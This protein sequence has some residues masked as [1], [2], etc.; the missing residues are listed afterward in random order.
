MQSQN[1]INEMF[2]ESQL[3]ACACAPSIML[4]DVL[5]QIGV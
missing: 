1:R 4:L 2:V 5:I 3:E